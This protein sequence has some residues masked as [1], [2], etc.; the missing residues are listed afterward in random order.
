M[1]RK[2]LGGA[3]QLLQGDTFDGPQ[4]TGAGGGGTVVPDRTYV[5]VLVVLDD[6]VT[7]IQAKDVT[8]RLM[9]TGKSSTADLLEPTTAGAP[10]TVGS[11]HAVI[12][13]FES[14]PVGGYTALA[15]VT[16]GSE[17]R[18]YAL[19]SHAVFAV[20]GIGIIAGVIASSS[21]PIAS[22]QD[23][24][25]D[26]DVPQMQRRRRVLA[27]LFRH[28]PRAA[29]P[30]AKQL[31]FKP[32]YDQGEFQPMFEAPTDGVYNSC[33]AVAATMMNSVA[34]PGL[35]AFNAHKSPGFVNYKSGSVPSVGDN[36]VLWEVD[37]IS[38]E[39]TGIVVQSN[40]TKG[41]IWFTADGG[42]R[43]VMTPL[44][45]DSTGVARRTPLSPPSNEAGFIVPRLFGEPRGTGQGELGNLHRTPAA[46][47]ANGHLIEGWLD[48]T[49]PQV[50]FANPS[51]DPFTGSE[52]DYQ[53]M[54]K[55]IARV[56]ELFKQ[57]RQIANA[58]EVLG[59]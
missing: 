6:A 41:S 10:W 14:V 43:D 1:I 26:L 34:G 32:D 57:E 22:V 56:E 47:V 30:L 54:R 35:Y 55:R 48:I 15:H 28:L 4:G 25:L 11:K 24:L 51:Y 52:Q 53:N 3:L 39:H 50:G 49:H 20:A 8:A 9:P 58:M 59:I 33:T 40:A 46:S 5:M 21:R 27:T 45:L 19:G 29:N 23:P 2:P 17:P 31:G 42:Q 13:G 7:K 36:Y 12:F 38:R 37:P 44:A 18:G 16:G